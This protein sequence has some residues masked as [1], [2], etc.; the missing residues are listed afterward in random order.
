MSPSFQSSAPT[1]CA[2]QATAEEMVAFSWVEWP[3]KATRD[4]AMK[5]MMEKN[6]GSATDAS[7]E[8]PPK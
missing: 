4:A 7:Q 8:T 1:T 5:K 2:A 6:H 3:Y